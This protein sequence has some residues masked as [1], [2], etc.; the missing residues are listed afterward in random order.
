MKNRDLR[1]KMSVSTKGL[2]PVLINKYYFSACEM[3]LTY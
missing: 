3:K 2:M 1:E